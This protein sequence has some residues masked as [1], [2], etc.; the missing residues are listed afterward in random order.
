MRSWSRASSFERS[1]DHSQAK[2]E[3]DWRSR[4]DNRPGLVLSC[5]TDEKASSE[6]ELEGD[7]DEMNNMR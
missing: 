1:I 5:A 3:S 2:L 7:G 6:C 4:R